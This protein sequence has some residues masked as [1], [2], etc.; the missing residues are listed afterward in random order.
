MPKYVLIIFLKKKNLF[1]TLA[2]KNDLKHIKY[3]KFK[4]KLNFLKI[5]FPPRFQT[6]SRKV[7][8]KPNGF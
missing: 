5:Q 3:I 1:L 4:K 2:H 7:I 6:Y 8:S